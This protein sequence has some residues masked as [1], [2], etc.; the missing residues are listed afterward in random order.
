[1]NFRFIS[2][3]QVRDSIDIRKQQLE[4]QHEH[5]IIHRRSGGV[6]STEQKIDNMEIIKRRELK[7]ALTMLV[8]SINT[9]SM[10]EDNRT[11]FI[12]EGLQ[13]YINKLEC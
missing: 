12:R 8:D 10:A 9:S 5:D 11:T 4:R 6:N 2:G 7:F 13:K 3:N 1:M